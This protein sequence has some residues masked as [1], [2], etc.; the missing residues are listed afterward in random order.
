[1]FQFK[2][3]VFKYVKA[4]SL[5]KCLLHILKFLCLGLWWFERKMKHMHN[6]LYDKQIVSV[7]ISF[8]LFCETMDSC[9]R[10]VIAALKNLFYDV[11]ENLV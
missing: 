3:L 9:H 2:Q 7:E 4:L 8:C 11:S 1:M 5:T 6:L 10:V